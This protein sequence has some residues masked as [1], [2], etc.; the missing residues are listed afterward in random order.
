M[1]NPSKLTLTPGAMINPALLMLKL[2][3]I[4]SVESARI[5]TSWL[6]VMVLVRLI[7]WL[8]I[9]DINLTVSPGSAQFM[10][11]KKLPN[12]DTSVFDTVRSQ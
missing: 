1:V 4:L 3:I 12:P 10:A 11:P 8:A 5:L 7:L 2:R 9:S 6:R